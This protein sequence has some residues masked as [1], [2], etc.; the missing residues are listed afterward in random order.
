MEIVLLYMSKEQNLL[1]EHCSLKIII[2]KTYYFFYITVQCIVMHVDALELMA[3]EHL[4]LWHDIHNIF[5]NQ[6]SSSF[7]KKKNGGRGG[8]DKDM[9]ICV[10]PTANKTTSFFKLT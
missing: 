1:Y 6:S 5:I 4:F 8:A 9:I 7:K 10:M 2:I 3:L